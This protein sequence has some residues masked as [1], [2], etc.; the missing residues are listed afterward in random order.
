MSTPIERLARTLAQVDIRIGI[1]NAPT[2]LDHFYCSRLFLDECFCRQPL[3]KKRVKSSLPEMDSFRASTLTLS[4][5]EVF[6]L[7][8]KRSRN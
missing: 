6:D 4:I 8:A 5:F 1:D 3:E 2:L 7:L